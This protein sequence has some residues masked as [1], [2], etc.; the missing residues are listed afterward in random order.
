VSSPLLE[1]LVHPKP[2]ELPPLKELP[3][4]L[5]KGAGSVVLGTWLLDV[6]RELGPCSQGIHMPPAKTCAYPAWGI[7][8][9]F[10]SGQVVRVSLY[11]AGREIFGS[12]VRSKGFRGKSPEGITLGMKGDD[13]IG[14]LGE[15]TQ[16]LAPGSGPASDLWLWK[17]QGV[18]LEL[19]N[20][21]VGAI[22]IPRAA[23][24]PK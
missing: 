11:R 17:K 2:K 10:E 4:A 6:E 12:H 22:H 5:G 21:I 20:G 23:G 7:D 9:G 18:G 15:P 13:A 14:K 16:K 19:E 24:R 8:V 3:I 1:G